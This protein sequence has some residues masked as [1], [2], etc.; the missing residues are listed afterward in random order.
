MLPLGVTVREKLL[1]DIEAHLS[2]VQCIAQIATLE[3][4]SGRNPAERQIEEALNFVRAA[5]PRIGED[6]HVRLAGNLKFGQHR[7]S[8]LA[9]V[10]D[11][12]KVELNLRILFDRFEPATTF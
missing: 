1:E 10:P 3:N 5:R 9:A 12:D 11:R 4:P 7:S 6:G 2:V 8:I